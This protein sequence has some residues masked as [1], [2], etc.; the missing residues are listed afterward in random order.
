MRHNL[1]LTFYKIYIINLHA[2]T[3]IKETTPDGTPDENVFNI[4][5]GVS[6]SIFV[7]APNT[8][9]KEQLAEVYYYDLYGK[10]TEKFAFLDENSLNTIPLNLI[11][12]LLLK[13]SPYKISMMISLA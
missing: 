5:Q 1:L 10:R 6:I 7:K 13:T 8:A 2:N 4:M 12:F 11:I 9:P 3:K